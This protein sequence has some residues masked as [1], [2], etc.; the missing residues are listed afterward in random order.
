MNKMETKAVLHIGNPLK[1]EPHK[2]MERA[3]TMHKENPKVR[4]ICVVWEEEDRKQLEAVVDKTYCEILFWE[5]DNGLQ[6]YLIDNL[7]SLLGAMVVGPRWYKC[8][9]GH[10]QKGTYKELSLECETCKKP[11]ELVEPYRAKVEEFATVFGKVLAL[12]NFDTRSGSFL[13]ELVNPTRNILLNMPYAIGCKHEA[14]AAVKGSG[15]GKGAIICGAGNHLEDAIPDIRRLQDSHVI[16]AVGR[17]YKLLKAEGV[18]VDYAVS[19]EMFD[20]DAAIFDGLTDVG[21]TVL[22]FASVCSPPAVQKWPGRRVCMWDLE[23]AKLLD[24]DDGIFGG[25][26]VAH[27]MMNFAFQTLDVESVI[28]CGID[29]AYTKT[30]THAAGTSPDTWPESVRKE[31]ATYQE[32]LWVPCTAKGQTFDPECHRSIGMTGGGGIALGPIEVRSSY[33]Y[34]DFATLF[35]ILIARHGRKVYNACPNGQKIEGAE[36]VDLTTL[37]L[38]QSA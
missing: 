33:S 18:R 14:P 5:G 31:D 22:A 8:P 21:D 9:D 7:Q 29:L 25:N 20:W 27:H 36:F 19:V 37:G 16:L 6:K 28:M 10:I 35:G 12:A 30:K 3:E 11:L 4:L 15:K 26:S 24:R 38:T 32:E 17:A 34:R 13:H 23:T 1:E 2:S